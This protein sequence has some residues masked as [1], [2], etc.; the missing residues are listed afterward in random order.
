MNYE[1]VKATTIEE[2]LGTL[3]QSIVEGWKKHLATSK[4][5][6]HKALN[7][8]YD[9]ALEAVDAIIEH[10]MG[11][12]GKVALKNNIKSDDLDTIE[13]FELLREFAIKGASLLGDDSE[14]HSDLDNLLGI[15]D[16]TLYQLREL[17]ESKHRNGLVS[18][19]QF[20]KESLNEGMSK[21]EIRAAL[22]RG[23]SPAELVK[24]NKYNKENESKPSYV[25]YYYD[26]EEISHTEMLYYASKAGFDTNNRKMTVYDSI[27]RAAEKGNR[28]A[29]ELL[30]HLTRVDTRERQQRKEKEYNGV[31]YYE[32]VDIR[33]GNVTFGYTV[34][35][36]GHS[37]Y[38]KSER[39]V[40]AFITKY[41]EQ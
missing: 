5:S 20:L 7:Q 40:K 12:N 10:Y 22:D 1:D 35:V 4:Y 39:A 11:I 16:S 17:T 41:K 8:Y 14:L 37:L 25:R 23:V 32:D 28:R 6:S 13:Y 33:N 30:T 18:L 26:G 36:N 21:E 15:I 38:T 34:D 9:D 27:E 19:S 3:Q 29:Q 24:M 31:T 2:Y